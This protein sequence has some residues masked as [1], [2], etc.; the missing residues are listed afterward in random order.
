MNF[1]ST[2]LTCSNI[3]LF[4]TLL[5]LF[6]PIKNRAEAGEFLAPGGYKVFQKLIEELQSKY[7]RA[8]ETE[9]MGPKFFEVQIKFQEE[10]VKLFLCKTIL[11]SQLE[12]SII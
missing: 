2:K 9:E 5:N 4:Q 3:L 12:A 7:R 6:A 10:V 1:S 8:G 11:K